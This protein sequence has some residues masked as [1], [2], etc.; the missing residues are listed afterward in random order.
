MQPDERILPFI[1]TND[2][3]PDDLRPA[4]REYLSFLS[5]GI[6]SCDQSIAKLKKGLADQNLISNV[7]SLG[8]DTK[9]LVSAQHYFLE[10]KEGLQRQTRLFEALLSPVRLLPLE[11]L[12]AIMLFVVAPGEFMGPYERSRCA[13]LRA[14]CRS[15]KDAVFATPTFWQSAR[16]SIPEGLSDDSAGHAAQYFANS[17]ISW[18]SRGGEA[19]LRL[20]V[21]GATELHP[22]TVMAFICT[23]T[24]FNINTLVLD[25]VFMDFEELEHLTETHESPSRVAHLS[26][27]LRDEVNLNVDLDDDTVLNFDLASNFPLLRTLT[28]K[29][30]PRLSF[31]V[32]FTHKLKTL[33]SL[34]LER[35]HYTLVTFL[36]QV[37]NL[38][39][40]QELLLA[41]C[42]VVIASH[43]PPPSMCIHSSLR[44][45]Q[46]DD[47]VLP[48]LIQ[49]LT[50]PSLAY[51]LIEGAP[52]E[53]V[54][55]GTES[56]PA[57]GRTLS[58]FLNRSQPPNLTL[59][60]LGSHP[61]ALLHHI[62]STAHTIHQ[63]RIFDVTDMQVDFDGL[64]TGVLVIPSSLK[65][66]TCRE[67]C[68]QERF[69]DWARS[70]EE[71]MGE[72]TYL[73]VRAPSLDGDGVLEKHL[74]RSA[75]PR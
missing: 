17:L 60:F 6:S 9:D 44:T 72:Q 45:L 41:R 30:N 27:H 49:Y 40:L 14:V 36:S 20:W 28:I 1:Y 12:S 18:F 68:R 19:P 22:M 54:R 5:R 2:P 16:I 32:T 67:S 59:S 58:N 64:N 71:C 23:C 38:P 48:T 74:S 47:D 75:D 37:L 43:D 56:P 55:V 63:L 10:M 69:M 42:Q 21:E 26:I 73:V 46:F 57:V 52:S 65:V 39:Y 51:L 29:H 31:P 24:S 53:A 15:W 13:T 50:C 66:I 35:V 11:L 4:C 3:L 8:L 7:K 70:L 33:T 62:L 25:N 34:R 61:K